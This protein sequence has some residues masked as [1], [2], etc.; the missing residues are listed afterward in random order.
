MDDNLGCGR[1]TAAAMTLPAL[2]PAFRWSHEPWGHGLRCRPLESIAQHLFTTRQLALRPVEGRP[3]QAERAWAQAAAS[4]GASLDQ[5]RRVK[6]V[7]GRTVRV[8]ARTES[9]ACDADDR[10][11]ADAQVSDRPN[12]VLAVQVADCVPL[13]IADS[14]T[15]AVAAVHAG[16]RGTCAGI[17]GAAVAAMA[18][19]FAAQPQDLV[20]AI[21]PSIGGCCYEVGT[22]VLE[23]FR[24][25]GVSDGDLSRWFSRMTSGSLALDVSAANRDQL[26]AAGVPVSQIYVAGLCT[27]THAAVFDSYRAAKEHAGRMGGLIRVPHR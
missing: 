7:H 27:R 16:W 17:A 24:A 25:N 2:N 11:E 14:R 8:L 9:L 4:L 19:A 21:G 22:D 3:D 6:Q 5:V 12:L 15:G 1:E 10:P 13:L 18:Q 20:A 23:A 26:Q